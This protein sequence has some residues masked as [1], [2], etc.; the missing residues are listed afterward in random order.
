MTQRF[1]ISTDELEARL[2][3][4]DLRVLDASWR[5]DGGDT[6]AAWR[7]ERLPGAQF[8]DL[9]A[10]SDHSSDLPH[11][12]PTAE[13]FAAA[14]SALGVNERDRIVVYDAEGLFSAARA[15][16][17]LRA[18]GAG[19]VQVLDGGLP[20]WRAEGRRLERGAPARPRPADFKARLDPSAVATLS[21]VRQ[22]LQGEAQVID[23]RGAPRFRGDAAEPRPG[24]RAGH[25]PGAINL[26]YGRLL[27]ADGTMKRGLDLE[28]AFRD[29]GVDLDRPVVTSC[30]S[31]V[32]AA[33]L[34]LGLAELGRTS[35]L[36][37]GSWA[38]WGARSDTPVEVG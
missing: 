24:V 8:F 26:P 11:M 31:G 30:G 29:A 13:A 21:D 9:E 1:L 5:L 22:A 32:T 33:I 27:N 38:E 2:G 25:M 23:A 36:Y 35:R 10:V 17:M 15:W 14:M 19:R 6:R 4:P 34:S 28:A 20:K 7:E 12:M 18:M 37:D 3:D 16:W